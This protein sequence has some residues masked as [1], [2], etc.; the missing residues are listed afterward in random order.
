[1]EQGGT[2]AMGMTQTMLFD[3]W[4]GTT[5]LA[6]ID[7]IPAP[8]VVLDESY[9]AAHMNAYT[10]HYYGPDER[11]R[12]FTQDEMRARFQTRYDYAPDVLLACPEKPS[13]TMA[14]PVRGRG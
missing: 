11:G 4:T 13:W 6:P 7:P 9:Y 8:V 3:T 12:V 5:A 10:W 2:Q 14:G 1:M